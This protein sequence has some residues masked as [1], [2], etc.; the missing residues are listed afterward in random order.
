MTFIFFLV[1]IAVVTSPSMRRVILSNTLPNADESIRCEWLRTG[2]NRAERQSLIGRLANPRALSLRVKSTPIP[3]PPGDR[4]TIS[5]IITN[6]SVGTIAI[7]Y[8]PRQ[9]RFGD[10]NVS[11]GL[12]LIFNSP[13]NVPPGQLGQGGGVPES[14]I[15]LLGPRQSCVH[16]AD[17]LLNSPPD[18]RIPTGAAI[19]KAYYRN[20]ARGI[21]QAAAGGSQLFADQG[22]WVG[23]AESEEVPIPLASN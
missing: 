3:Q 10:D 18:A 20:T 9:L 6:E 16:R 21:A 23:V 14:D 22:L 13:L 19:V 12:G 15:K 17:I 2:F 1:I 11:N 7:I 8:N 4:I 5:I